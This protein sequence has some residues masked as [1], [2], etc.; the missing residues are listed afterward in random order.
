MP[1]TGQNMLT[2][3]CV[4]GSQSN[5]LNCCPSSNWFVASYHCLAVFTSRADGLLKP[6]VVFKPLMADATSQ[7]TCSNEV[8]KRGQQNDGD[9]WP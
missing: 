2:I 6:K 5:P 9:V 8:V 3:M 1:V 7:P 4:M